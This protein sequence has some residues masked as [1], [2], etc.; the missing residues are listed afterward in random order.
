MATRGGARA[1]GIDDQIGSLEIGKRADLILVD[2]T[3]MDQ[4]PV[5]DPLFV[6][7]T[8]VV[9]RDV[10]SVIIDGKVVMKEREIL[11]VDMDAL[12][13]RLRRQIPELMARFEA[14]IA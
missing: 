8:V 11:T 5:H 9:G 12:K 3:D 14:M 7:S 6:A 10:R 1:L 13:S 2:C 4:V